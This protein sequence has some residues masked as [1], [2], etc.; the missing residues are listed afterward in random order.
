MVAWSIKVA[1]ESKL[2]EHIVV[3]T[4]DEEIAEVAQKYGAEVPFRRPAELADDLSS[5]VPV[6]AHATEYCIDIGWPVQ[7]V[8][9]IYPCSPLIQSDDLEKALYLLEKEQVD[10]VYPVTEYPHPIQRAMRIL[11]GHKM[12]FLNPEFELARTQDLETMYHDAGQ[13]YAGKTAAWLLHKKMHTAG[14]GMPIPHWRVVD[15]DTLDDWRRAEFFFRLFSENG[16]AV[17]K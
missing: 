2:F 17:K 1:Q 8:Y 3:S 16:L 14:I 10:Y 13:F 12:Q 6:I 15:I 4:D 9:C 7:Y 5:T 11:P